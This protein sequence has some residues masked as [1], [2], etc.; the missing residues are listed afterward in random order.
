MKTINHLTCL[1]VVLF[2][3]VWTTSAAAAVT[4]YGSFEGCFNRSTGNV[5]LSISDCFEGRIGFEKQN[6]ISAINVTEF[7]FEIDG[8]KLDID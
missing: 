6:G 3:L 5:P 7:W 4:Y 2:S 8:K 1:L